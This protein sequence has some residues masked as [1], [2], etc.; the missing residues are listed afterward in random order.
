[1]RYISA[2]QLKLLLF[3][4]LGIARVG[5]SQ[6]GDPNLP[7]DSLV[8]HAIKQSNLSYI[9]ALVQKFG[10]DFTFHNGEHTLLSYS[11]V[12]GNI[13]VAK[14]VIN[15]AADIDLLN[16]DLTPLMVCA[17]YNRD[18]IAEYL[19]I[20]KAEIDKY[21][22]HRNTALIIAA[23]Y[24]HLEVVK[25]LSKFNA[26]PFI[27]NFTNQSPLDY[28]IRF[29]KAEVTEFLKT[30]MAI[31]ANRSNLHFTDG[32]HV[33]WGVG[34][35]A[36]AVYLV[37]DSLQQKSVT[38]KE[39]FKSN[40]DTLSFSGFYKDTLQYLAVKKSYP[41][42]EAYKLNGI[43]KIF[44]IGD[45]HGEYANLVKLL[46]GNGIIDSNNNW[47]WGNGHVVFMGDLFDRGTEVTQTL[48]LVYK[49]YLQASTKGGFV[50]LILGNHELMILTKDF[51]FVEPRYKYLYSS[52]YWDY[53]DPFT[54]STA[55]GAWIRSRN[56][57][58]LLNGNLFVHG[59]YST[60]MV[61]QNITIG[62]LNSIIYNALMGVPIND[63]SEMEILR[64]LSEEY[65][66]FWYRG[67]MAESYLLPR[68]NQDELDAVLNF[69]N[70]KS[71]IVGHTEVK[72]IIPLYNGKV[73]PLNVP[74]A[75]P[76]I[77]PKGLLINDTGYYKCDINGNCEKL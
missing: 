43:S 74:F 64:F 49:L 11:I 33:F 70:A 3:L 13:E 58:I 4:L 37:R 14:Y 17:T 23:R 31:F 38:V 66:P 5:Y 55:L 7:V 77:M 19:L 72:D 15:K 44:A 75:K 40:N 9:D 32:P 26:N 57:A 60:K 12:I 28:A 10:P 45:V 29:S 53:S 30:Y 69:C 61:E 54:T 22:K 21:N 46:R 63:P 67:L 73:F 16:N 41:K 35:R 20:N 47:I 62:N 27:E 68:M 39:T 1:M 34:K 59:G 25:V 65:G 6:V 56:T 2:I 52:L 8:V 71:M 48:W 42:P 36:Q 18:K 51:R 76:G 50:H 24:G